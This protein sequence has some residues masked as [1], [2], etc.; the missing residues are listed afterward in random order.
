MTTRKLTR[1]VLAS[2]LA[3]ALAACGGGG[4]SADGRVVASSAGSNWATDLPASLKATSA[5][6]AR[7]KAEGDEVPTETDGQ[8]TTTTTGGSTAPDTNAGT[9]T[10]AGGTGG[11]GTTTGSGSGTGTT[12]NAGTGTTTDSGTGT[13]TTAQPGTTGQTPATTP[14]VGRSADGLAGPAGAEPGSYGSVTLNEEWNG[15]LDASRWNTRLSHFTSP[16]LHNWEIADGLLKMWTPHDDSGNFVFQNRALNTEGKFSQRYGWFE[17]EAKLPAGPGLW[18]SFWLYGVYG[19]TRPE[20]D[21]MESFAGIDEW[22]GDPNPIDYGAA[23]WVSDINGGPNRL[24][25]ARPFHSG[26]TMDYSA[27]FHKFGAKWEPDGI[28]FYVDGK[29]FGGKVQ[30]GALNQE[31]FIIV[32]MGTGDPNNVHAPTSRTPTNSA[33]EIN[34]VRVWELTPGSTGGGSTGGGST[35]GGSTGGSTTGGSTTGGSTVAAN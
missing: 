15:P 7:A 24:G 10:N 26:I 14:S 6:S 11:T 17:M 9:T 12:T 18:P 13:G 19:T 31:L 3:A 25:S 34:Y 8:T 32:A 21:I 30:T 16:D 5:V 1:L 4:E 28:T 23:V 33:F 22:W 29:P 2:T 35:G 20:I 27:A